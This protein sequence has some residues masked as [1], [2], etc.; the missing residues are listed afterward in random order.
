MAGDTDGFD[1]LTACARFL[2]YAAGGTGSKVCQGFRITPPEVALKFS[3]EKTPT[4]ITKSATVIFSFDLHAWAV[5]ILCS[6]NRCL[7]QVV[8]T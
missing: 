2:P 4:T 7:K 1:R 6:Y 5:M 3:R 8:S